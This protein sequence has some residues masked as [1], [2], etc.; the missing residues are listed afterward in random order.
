MPL[1]GLLLI[2]II[3]LLA[4]LQV[5]R[6]VGRALM[7]AVFIYLIPISTADELVVP[8]CSAHR[9]RLKWHEFFLWFLLLVLVGVAA[10][11]LYAAVNHDVQSSE[12]ILFGCLAGAPVLLVVSIVIRFFTPRMTASESGH[13]DMAMLSS[14]F[15]RALST[16]QPSLH[17][18]V[19]QPAGRPLP[20]G[21][22]T[23]PRWLYYA[24]SGGMALLALSILSCFG[25]MHLVV[26]QHRHAGREFAARPHARAPAHPP[27]FQPPAPS[28]V[29]PPPPP[30]A[31]PAPI[32][33][34]PAALPPAAR[35]DDVARATSPSEKLPPPS[36]PGR[37]VRHGMAALGFEVQTADELAADDLVYVWSDQSW[38]MGK[39]T[40]VAADQVRVRL[41][42]GRPTPGEWYPVEYVRHTLPPAMRSLAAKSR[43]RPRAVSTTPPP[44]APADPAQP[45]T[46]G[47]TPAKMPAEKRGKLRTWTDAS[48]KFQIEAELVKVEDEQAVLRKA[49]GSI[50][51]VPLSKLSVEDRLQAVVQSP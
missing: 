36:R 28:L 46:S 31:A 49:D 19:N 43:P 16:P 34:A 48:G 51:R 7:L 50:V 39:A 24:A 25:L 2:A 14:E 12:S 47:S 1:V 44:T 42:G 4:W 26:N 45:T 13:I 22:A 40:E 23:I 3:T 5:P 41:M 9:Y 27:V 17:T 8:V 11:G 37:D 38:R 6:A 15:V 18:L 29:P 30:P 33:P 21:L 32:A 10:I 20:S 35:A